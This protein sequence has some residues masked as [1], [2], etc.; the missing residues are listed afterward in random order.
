[1]KVKKNLPD[2]DDFVLFEKIWRKHVLQSEKVK[3]LGT[4]SKVYTSSLWIPKR[5]K[6][7]R[8]GQ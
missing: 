7:F 1:M 3:S 6:P 8:G 2:Y 4:N 5:G